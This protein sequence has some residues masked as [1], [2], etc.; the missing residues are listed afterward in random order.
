MNSGTR[1]SEPH[2][3]TPPDASRPPTMPHLRVVRRPAT[4]VPP[5]LAPPP[6]WARPVSPPL[7]PLD[8]AALVHDPSVAN[9][10]AGMLTKPTRD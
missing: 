4:P 6:A 1:H 5:T 8:T 2:H 3:L 9:A 10:F 7:P